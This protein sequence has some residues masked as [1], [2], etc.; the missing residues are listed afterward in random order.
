M[1]CMRH[2]I[3]RGRVCEVMYGK[4][5]RQIPLRGDYEVLQV[6]KACVRYRT[7]EIVR[8][9]GEKMCVRY[10]AAEIVRSCEEKACVRYHAVVFA[11]SFKKKVAKRY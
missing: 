11:R 1:Y 4:N 9:C 10:R 8:S 7:A 2:Q 5:V 6:K 3:P